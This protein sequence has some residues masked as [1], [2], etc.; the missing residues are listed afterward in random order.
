MSR[1]VARF[2]HVAVLAVAGTGLV[3]AWMAWLAQ[4][5]DEFA[6]VNH[7][8]Q[9]ELQYWHVLAAPLLVF[10]VGLIWRSHVWAS[11]RNPARPRRATGIALIA[12]FAPMCVSGYALQVAHDPEWRSVWVWTHGITSIAWTLGYLVHQ[13]APK[14]QARPRR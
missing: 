1:S 2:V 6:I 8:W 5:E 9:P 10:A 12:L 7:P 11:F 4:P 3:Y 14:R 13:L